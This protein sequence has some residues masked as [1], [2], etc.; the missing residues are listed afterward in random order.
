MAT[1]TFRALHGTVL[2]YM[3]S[4]FTRVADVRNR[5]RLRSASSNQLDVP[6]IRLSTVGSRAFPVAGAKAVSYTHLRAHETDSYLVC[7]LLRSTF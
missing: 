4:Q 3:T 5:R 1:L 2:P 6:S 7:R